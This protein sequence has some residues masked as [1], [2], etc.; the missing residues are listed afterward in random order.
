M[1]AI[2][3]AKK[4]ARPAKI[5][6]Q[7]PRQPTKKAGRSNR[8]KITARTGGAFDKDLSQKGSSAE[9]VRSKKGDTVGRLGKKVGKRKKP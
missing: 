6:I 1:A 9:G 8:K 3:S 2:R 4:S 5:G 7:V